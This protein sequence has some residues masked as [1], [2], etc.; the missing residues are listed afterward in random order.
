MWKKMISAA[1]P[2]GL[3]LLSV[4]ARAQFSVSPSPS[5]APAANPPP[6]RDIPLVEK[7]WDALSNQEVGEDGRKALAIK[8][9]RWKHAETENF[10]VHFRR[11]TE[12]HIV[13]REI[14]YDIWFVAKT[15]GAARQDYKRKSHVFVFEDEG[16]WIAFLSGTDNP[17]WFSSFA[18]HDELFLNIR[19][20]TN[21]GQFDSHTL[22]HE[23]THATVARLYP[24]EHWPV[25]LGEGFAEYMGGASVASRTHQPLKKFQS[26][27]NRAEM[28]LDELF[29]LKRYPEDRDKISQLY[30]TGE[31]FVRFLMDELP[32]D[33]FRKFVTEVLTTKDPEEAFMRVYGDKFKDFDSFRKKFAAFSK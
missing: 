26:T 33:R 3:L 25:W 17:L 18:N 30:Q 29:A 11:V 12:A 13:V 31:K 32:Q 15:L 4:C 6:P 27:L 22:A 24:F 2:A 1:T 28:P 9:A 19:R 10:I 8:P 7:N 14:E 16:E 21:G 20:T 5:P 23:T